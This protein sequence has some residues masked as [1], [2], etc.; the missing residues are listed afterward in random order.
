[1]KRLV[2][3]ILV[4]L[5]PA[6][7][8]LAGV[9]TVGV[10]ADSRGVSCSMT[11]N[12]GNSLIITYVV[13]RFGPGEQATNCRFKIEPPAGASWQYIGFTGAFFFSGRADI[14][15]SVE[16]GVCTSTQTLA[17]AAYWYSLAASPACGE[18]S[19]KGGLNGQLA[20][21]D[22]LYVYRPLQASD[23]LTVNPSPACS[24]DVLATEPAT[25]GKVKALYR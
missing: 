23:P 3:S 11:D 24:C 1:M 4:V 8:V 6:T 14:D 15:I 7:P 5:V 18:L 13:H 25:W 9:G 16:Y 22:C 2:L 10:Y 17:G 21:T 19:I 20:A 12:G